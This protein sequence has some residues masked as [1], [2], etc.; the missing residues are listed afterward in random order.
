MFGILALQMD[1]VSRDALISAMNSWVLDKSKSLGEIL[2]NQNALA[3]KRLAM[4]ESL[5]EEHLNQHGRDPEKSLA[6]VTPNSLA[7]EKL[8]EIADPEVQAS[9]ARAL[10]SLP[11]DGRLAPEGT[12]VYHPGKSAGGRFVI[13]RP[14]AKGGLGEVFVALDEELNREVALKEIQG[15]YAHDQISRARFVLEAE[16]TGRLEHPAIVPVYSFGQHE[17]GRPYY[18][19]RFIQGDSL[20]TAIKRFYENRS[21]SESQRA[22]EFR[23]LLGAF[24]DVC[25]AIHYA[26]SR[27]ILHRDLKPDNIMLGKFGETLIVDWG[28]AK[29]LNEPVSQM[30]VPQP[31]L[32]EQPLRPISGS[33]P[34]ETLA[35]TALGTPGYM[36]PE[37]ALGRLDLMGVRSDIYSLGATLYCLLTGQS[38]FVG[39]DVAAILPLVQKGDF[40]S[41]RSVN[42][43]VSVALEAIC[44]KAMACEPANRYASARDLAEDLDHWLADEPVSALREALQ[45]RLG[46]WARRHKALVTGTAALLLTAVAALSLGVVLLGHANTQIQDQRD[47]AEEQ[48]GQAVSNLY[49]SL[50][51]EAQAIRRSR[52]N[53]YRTEVLKRL[54][55]ALRLE[56]PDKDPLELR[57]EATA[58]QGDFIGVEPTTWEDFPANLSYLAL[59]PDGTQLAVG[60]YD[61]V[62]LIRHIPDG[63]T[64]AKLSGHTS[65]ILALVF[66]SDGKELVSGEVRGKVK[67]WQLNDKGAWT[68]VKTIF[69]E[70][71]VAFMLPSPVL[72]FFTPF[73]SERRV[74]SAA[75]TPDGRYLAVAG[76]V[77]STVVLEDLLEGTTAARFYPPE[78]ENIQ[79]LALSPDGRLLAGGYSRNGTYGVLV[80]NFEKRALIQRILPDLER[81]SQV[82]FTP[83]GQLLACVHDGGVALYDTSTFQRRLYVRGDYPIWAAFSPDSQLLAI[84]AFHLGAIRLWNV[85]T[86]R[87]VAVLRSPSTLG[88]ASASGLEF[89]KDGKKLVAG[90][91][92]SI[93]IWNLAGKGERRVL[94]GHVGGVPDVAFSPDGKILA[95]AGKDHK[96][97]I[98]DPISGNLVRELTEFQTPVQTL[99]FSPDGRILAAGDYESGTVRFYDLQLWKELA[100]MQPQ[101]GPAVW[102]SSFSADGQYFAA[103]GDF[104]LTLWRVLRGTPMKSDRR[105]VSLELHSRLAE[106]SA[107]SICFSPDGNW[108]AWAG[109]VVRRQPVRINIWDLH[110]S[111]PKALSTA[112]TPF[113]PLLALGFHA[114][115]KHLTFVNNNGAIADWDVTT[116]QEAFSF[117]QG[118]LDHRGAMPPH[119]RLSADGAW[120]A[121]GGRNPTIWDMES[122]KLLVA[123]PEERS[124]VWCVGWSP[125]RELLAV[126][127]SDGGL[128]IW[129]L[130][131]VKA[132]LAEIG[133][134]WQ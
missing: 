71:M 31:S 56:T 10:G 88:F 81:F 109:S 15:S 46:R 44:L 5:V 60:L 122:K 84:S 78:G 69:V 25:Q 133:L 129:N 52:E 27:G 50:V 55:Q 61:G 99:T 132:Q 53:G 102:A 4:L 124:A 93:R 123:L 66:R 20:K 126:G 47:R 94:G 23:R 125:N 39:S 70:P 40:P 130:P 134:G 116:G 127:T 26:H 86:N 119:T 113:Q 106:G 8:A 104:G 83:D 77:D 90:G 108:L 72:P 7:R 14:H 128:V 110:A 112:A 98:W 59:H 49:H 100:V 30:E 63:A 65:P 13:L 33:G 92:K 37:Q 2:L 68:C 67:V 42:P 16:I 12:I 11:V 85:V 17:D 1:F 114:D 120:Y 74:Y 79:G 3:P 24:G 97:K 76:S 54:D 82:S 22:V 6:A 36:S 45:A 64:V 32:T 91:R 103:G 95:S 80:W 41:P 62:V 38:P 48:H 9:L 105:T 58:C 131:K 29:P 43:R 75:L 121:V 89:S 96:I 51:R 111:K 21:A 57:Q 87:E 118:E 101:V 28:L 107:R 117:A 34:V 115:S 18:A 73:L 19:M 35:G